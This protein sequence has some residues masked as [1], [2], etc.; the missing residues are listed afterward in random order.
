V[1]WPRTQRAVD[2]ATALAFLVACVVELLVTSSAEGPAWANVLG[3]VAIT[4]CLLARRSAPVGAALAFFALMIA[5]A[6]WLTPPGK[7]AVPLVALLFFPYAAALQG[8]ARSAAVVLAGIPVTV[9]TMAL[10]DDDFDLAGAA[11]PVVAG[12]AAYLVGRDVRSRLELAAELHEVAL[13]A[14]EEE[15]AL[16][17]AAVHEER[18]RIAREMHD[19]VAHSISVMVV[20]AGGAR[21]ILEQ[22]PTR[23]G[24]AAAQ[25]ER[26]G[27]DAL[28]E[29]RRLLGA[30]HPRA[31][32]PEM[33]PQPGLVEL[34]ALLERARAAGLPVELHEQGERRALPPGID[35][36]VYRILQEALTNSLKHSG[37]TPTDVHLVWADDAVE[38]EVLDGGASSNGFVD[39]Q[40]LIGM[41]ERVRLYGGELRAGRR[42][43]GGFRV[44]A[45]IPFTIE[46]TI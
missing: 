16:A 24:E 29:M 35:L 31:G 43:E 46:E 6:L 11:F 17:E 2:L 18:R 14:Q 39:G 36:A 42:Q 38:L 15:E 32:G 9:A 40:G 3:A 5:F 45:R 4:A 27:R 20:Q 33:A 7:L 26:V 21:K 25:I 37:P 23:A 1:I 44:Q 10:I 28:L 34:N 30:L 19:V 8:S 22:D 41:R 13:R 12:L